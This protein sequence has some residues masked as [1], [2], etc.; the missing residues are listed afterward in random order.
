MTTA[1]TRTTAVAATTTAGTTAAAPTTA[2]APTERLEPKSYSPNHP[3]FIV[4]SG[5]TAY[6]DVY[7]DIRRE[8][9]STV[10]IPV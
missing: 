6:I 1:V 4:I 3:H 10:T 2:T 8:Q 7:I 9:R 5:P